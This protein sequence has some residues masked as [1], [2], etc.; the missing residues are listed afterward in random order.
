MNQNGRVTQW[1][2]LLG[3]GVLS[4][5]E[6]RLRATLTCRLSWLANFLASRTLLS[7]AATSLSSSSRLLLSTMITAV[8]NGGMINQ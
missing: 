6:L 1:L 8:V 2:K 4:S 5:A 7:A 3:E